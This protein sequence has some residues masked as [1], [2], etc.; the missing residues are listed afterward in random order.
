MRQYDSLCYKL[1]HFWQESKSDM[2]NKNDKILSLWVIS[3]NSIIP[4]CGGAH[5]WICIEFSI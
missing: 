2:K 5:F 4:Y 1:T 3:S